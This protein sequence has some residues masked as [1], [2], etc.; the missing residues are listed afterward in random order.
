MSSVILSTKCVTKAYDMNGSRLEVLKGIDLDIRQ[1]EAVC[2]MGVSGAGKS[3]LL[4]IL[5]TL[6]Q[7]T[8]GK[9]YYRGED[10]TRKTDDQLASFRNRKMGFVFQFHHLLPELTALENVAL[11]ARIGGTSKVE[12]EKMALELLDQ[13]GL[14]KRQS[15]Y[16]SELSGGER[17]RVAIARALIQKPEILFAD[18]PSGNL[19]SENG[20]VIQDLF[21]ELKEKMGLT[22]V[23]VTHDQEF[24]NR[25]PKLYRLKNGVFI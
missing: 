11:A 25:F 13:L 6:D 9:V 7:P 12:A 16:P 17:Q 2:I 10:L 18:E 14:K 15:H 4:H 5:G 24:A 8:L 3:T 23:V 20:K 19:D 22:L 21:F 1:G